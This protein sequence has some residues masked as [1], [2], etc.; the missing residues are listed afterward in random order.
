MKS[1][2]NGLQRPALFLWK[3]LAR[4]VLSGSKVKCPI[5][6]G[7]LNSYFARI[8]LEEVFV[9][10]IVNIRNECLFLG[11]WEMN[12]S[13]EQT[14]RTRTASRFTGFV[15]SALRFIPH[16]PKKDTHSWNDLSGPVVNSVPSRALTMHHMDKCTVGI[17][18]YKWT[19]HYNVILLVKFNR[20]GSNEF[21]LGWWHAFP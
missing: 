11:S 8:I 17:L 5:S 18:L 2:Q 12:R 6:A 4:I 16:E 1:L 14:N 20:H 9:W 10:G 19:H 7:I 15:C 21:F 13:A 3:E